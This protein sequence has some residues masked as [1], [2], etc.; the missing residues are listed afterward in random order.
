[1]SQRK[2]TRA[3]LMRL[4]DEVLGLYHNSATDFYTTRLLVQAIM[5]KKRTYAAK[6][7]EL[8]RLIERAKK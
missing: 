7:E 8:Q 6:A 4:H 1:M 5:R 3:E 2:V